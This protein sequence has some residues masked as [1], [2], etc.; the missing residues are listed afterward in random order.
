MCLPQTVTPRLIT[1]CHKAHVFLAEARQRSRWYGPNRPQLPAALGG[2]QQHL[3]G[4]VAGDYGFDPLGLAVEPA[5]FAKYHEAE[6]LHARSV[7]T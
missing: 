7:G 6:L 2:Q 3:K 5:A 4:L 1:S